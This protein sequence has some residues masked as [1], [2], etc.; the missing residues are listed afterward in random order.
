[1]FSEAKLIWD[2]SRVRVSTLTT[3]GNSKRY[4]WLSVGENFFTSMNEIKFF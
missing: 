3:F 4:N 1:M 2:T